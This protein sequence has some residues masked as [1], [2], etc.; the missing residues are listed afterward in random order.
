M[1]HHH[2]K[3]VVSSNDTQMLMMA[4]KDTPHTTNRSPTAAKRT[5]SPATRKSRKPRVELDQDV[6]VER[7]GYLEGITARQVE[8]RDP[9]PVKRKP[10][11]EVKIREGLEEEVLA[12]L[13]NKLRID[14]SSGGFTDPNSRT[15]TVMFGR[16]K[17]TEATFDVVQKEEYGG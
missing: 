11:L 8:D 14:I 6:P 13:R 2:Y 1:K 5:A 17:L 9:K 16:I 10:E 3:M 15:V 4:T 12:L 7:D